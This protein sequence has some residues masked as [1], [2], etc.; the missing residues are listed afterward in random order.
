MSTANLGPLE[1]ARRL[2]L[3]LRTVKRYAR[4]REPETL[5][6]FREIK[7]L[8]YTGSLNLLYCYVT[9]GRTEG[10]RPIITCM[11]RRVKIATRRMCQTAHR[12]G[13]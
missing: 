8:G 6:M 10:D 3:S 7:Q 9:Q 12:R 5:Q 4:T 2:N 13:T 1:C 11:Y